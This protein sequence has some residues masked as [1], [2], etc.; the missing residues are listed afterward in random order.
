MTS[1]SNPVP[2]LLNSKKDTHDDSVFIDIYENLARNERKYSH[3]VCVCRVPKSLSCGKPEAFIPH[4]VGL[5]PYHHFRTVLVMTDELKLA[6]AKRV[7]QKD[8][9]LLPDNRDAFSQRLKNCVSDFYHEDVMNS[10]YDRHILRYVL[11]VDGLFLLALLHSGAPANPEPHFLTGKPGMPLVNALGVELTMDAVIRDVFMLENQIPTHVLKQISQ[12]N[13]NKIQSQEQQQVDGLGLKMENFCKQLCPLV[14]PEELSKSPGEHDHLL[15]LM[16]HL[17][18]P[19]PKPK[20]QPQP[21]PGPGHGPEPQPKTE[22]QKLE[23]E[24]KDGE[25]NTDSAKSPGETGNE[26]KTNTCCSICIVHLAVLGFLLGFFVY[27]V[28]KLFL[29]VLSSLFRVA[30]SVLGP[31]FG[32]LVKLSKC[33]LPVVD[34]SC[35]EALSKYQDQKVMQPFIQ[36]IEKIKQTSETIQGVHSTNGEKGA[37]PAV[38]IPSVTELHGAGIRFEPAKGGISHIKFDAET[39]Q[40]FLPVI[41]LDANSEVIMRNLVAYESLTRPSYLIFTRYVEIMRAIIDTPEDVKLLVHKEI[42]ETGLSDQVV[43]DL[44]NGMSKSTRPTNTPDLEKEIQKVNT[45][46]DRSQW[47]QRFVTKY[48][49]SSWKILTVVAALVFLVLTAV[50]T[51]CSI[52]GCS[53]RASSKL[54]KL[55]GDWDYGMNNDFISSM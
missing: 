6:A 18:A 42:I 25:G 37:R 32:L 44:F 10:V 36:L 28:W 8:Q 27:L 54:G 43:A 38:T 3:A 49:Y 48:V 2:V 33:L 47:L 46:F 23:S 29:W 31:L 35:E 7:L 9:N 51:Y 55:P 14:N 26:T 11:A 5:G 21:Q 16:F 50:Q 52:Y 22:T 41:K 53:S 20:P 39:C 15:D 17:V 45:E 24:G 30:K 40:F 19:K 12:V 13:D 4:F 34:S 1:K